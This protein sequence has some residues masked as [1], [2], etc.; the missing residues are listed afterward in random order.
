MCQN[1]SP[2][3]R[4][5]PL[6]LPKKNSCVCSSPLKKI[7]FCMWISAPKRKVHRVFSLWHVYMAAPSFYMAAPFLYWIFYILFQCTWIRKV[8]TWWLIGRFPQG[9][10]HISFS[11]WYKLTFL[12]K[13]KRIPLTAHYMRVVHKV[14]TSFLFSCYFPFY[15][16]ICTATLHSKDTFDFISCHILGS[17]LWPPNITLPTASIQALL[18]NPMIW[19][20]FLHW[21]GSLIPQITY[22]KHCFIF[23]HDEWSWGKMGIK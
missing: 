19:S 15:S 6:P 12:S 14:V 16:S 21:L 4:S 2:I 11:K 22:P 1:G 10:S 17:E 23:V 8:H 18:R 13:Q 20:T 7:T 3:S 9:C 5:G